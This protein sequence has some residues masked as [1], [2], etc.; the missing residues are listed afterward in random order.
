MRVEASR[1]A[2]AHPSCPGHVSTLQGTP[3]GCAGP[4]HSTHVPEG[5]R[6]PPPPHAQPRT[7]GG[8]GR[9]ATRLLLQLPSQTTLGGPGLPRLHR[10]GGLSGG[11][12]DWG[13]RGR[14]ALLPRVRVAPPPTF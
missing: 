13:G 1:L 10:F 8:P 11:I 4:G 2:P 12:K 6:E 5:C 3:A 14:A 9:Q 7:P